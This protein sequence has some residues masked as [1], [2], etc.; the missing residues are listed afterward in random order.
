MANS[1]TNK[2]KIEKESFLKLGM[3]ILIIALA[4]YI[5][6]FLYFRIDLTS[7]KRYTLSPIT[8][9]TLKNLKD[10]IY[11]TVYLDGDLPIGFSKMR[12]ATKELLDE[13]RLIGG[14][15]I[16]YR[17]V[18]PSSNPN[19]KE[20]NKFYTELY[21]K[22][23]QPTEVNEKSDEGAVVQKIVFPGAI[24]SY[25]GVD[26]P[27]NLLK[28][29]RSLSGEENLN[30][31]IQSLEYALIS[32]IKSITSDTIMKIAFIEGHGELD[33]YHTESISHE[34]STFYQIDRGVINGKL[35]ILDHYA[36][37][38]I[39]KPAKAFTENDKLVIDQYIMQGGKV[40]WLVDPVNIDMDS[41]A[42]GSTI[43]MINQINLD[44]Q[45]FR[46]GVRLNPNIVQDVQCG[47]LSV[48]VSSDVKN[49]KYV[50]AP[51]M[52]YP[53]IT[54][55]QDQPLTKNLNLI[56]LQFASTIDTVGNDSRI[57][58]TVLLRTSQYTKILNAPV[59]LD[60][61]EIRKN[62]NPREF[63]L[64]YQPVALMLEGKFSSVFRNRFLNGI[65][66]D[67]SIK[68][69][70]ESVF[71]RMA[72]VADGDIIRNEIKNTPNGPQAYPLGFDR[73]TNQTYGNGEFILNLVNY[74]TDNKGLLQIRAK[75]LKLRLLNKAEIKQSRLTWQLIN[76]VLPVVLVIAIGIGIAFFRKRK[77][78][79]KS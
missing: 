41:L 12:K 69:K 1:K 10:E 54:P 16:Q 59:A 64:S 65:I 34:L 62:P 55:S 19:I 8:K 44:D 76:V 71:T 52:Y 43:A 27:I 2:K 38:I 5:S 67:P 25:K 63:M 22:G 40:L 78:A 4:A 50:P 29:N 14:N 32:N 18:N 9:S 58:R 72:F 45:F 20:R 36:A 35:H 39:A 37:I 66:S 6:S 26:I 42:M 53:L 70:D 17:F 47:L 7:E 75:E 31:S 30:N 23:L 79:R 13:F 74:L 28:N 57:K 11:V 49:P 61:R 73:L 24:M 15:T 56:Q 3:I 21:N 51:W 46:Y 68:I 48:D 77:Y 33:Q 60:L